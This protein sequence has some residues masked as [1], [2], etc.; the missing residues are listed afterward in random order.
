MP[1]RGYDQTAVFATIGSFSRSYPAV[2]ESVTR[3][4]RDLE[5]FV[6]GHGATPAQMESIRLA[7]SEAVGNAVRHAYRGQ[8]GEVQITASA[9]GQELWVLVADD[10]CGFQ[11][12]AQT[13]GLGW[14]LALMAHATD[15]FVLAERAQGG[16]E[17]RMRFRIG[18]AAGPSEAGDP[19]DA[20]DPDDP[21]AAG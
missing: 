7:V 21:A 2:R 1:P 13:P 16:T 9:G 19:A 15:D 18:D 8:E 12:R 10:G 11:A 4:R 5:E 14:G 17:A 6:A 3:A 20:G